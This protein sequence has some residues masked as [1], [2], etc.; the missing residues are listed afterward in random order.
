MLL[1]CALPLAMGDPAAVEGENGPSSAE[2]PGV[3]AVGRRG[4]WR[5]PPG[6]ASTLRARVPRAQGEAG[7]AARGRRATTLRGSGD[8]PGDPLF[9]LHRAR[10]R[11]RAAV[12]RTD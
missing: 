4:L 7:G 1:C 6:V 3:A 11:F 12:R 8:T 9:R 2:L 10:R 5:A